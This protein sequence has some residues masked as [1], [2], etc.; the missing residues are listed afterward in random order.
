MN[1]AMGRALTAAF[2]LAVV[3]AVA[4]QGTGGNLPEVRAVAS[5]FKWVKT[6]S[7]LEVATIA[8]NQTKP[9][10]YTARVKY[11]AGMRLAP[12][13]HPD[14]RVTVVLSGTLYFGYGEQFDESKLMALP[15]GSVYTE[16]ARQ[17]HFLWAKDGETTIQVTGI[18]PSGSTPVAAKK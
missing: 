5:D 10:L 3:S 17:P 1:I 12:H 14:D 6:P 13:F 16:P 15:A 7:G 8:G 11:P 9:G 18:G 4:A 2:L